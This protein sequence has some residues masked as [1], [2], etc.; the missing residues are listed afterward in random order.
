[1]ETGACW[2]SNIF[3]RL[4]SLKFIERYRNKNNQLFYL[5]DTLKDTHASNILLLAK[6][7]I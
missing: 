7:T 6:F 1:M 5:F 2:V 4:K 3:I